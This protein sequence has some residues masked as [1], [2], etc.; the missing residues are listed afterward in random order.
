MALHELVSYS[1]TFSDIPAPLAKVLAEKAIQA[2]SGAV[3]LELEIGD[4]KDGIEEAENLA[5]EWESK[6]DILEAN[7]RAARKELDSVEPDLELIRMYLG[8]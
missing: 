3:E 6:L 2:I 8:E 5:E 4:L 1:E 7:V